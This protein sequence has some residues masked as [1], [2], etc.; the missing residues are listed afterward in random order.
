MRGIEAY[1][2]AKRHRSMRDQEA[3]VFLRVNA[4]L[5]A[6]TGAAADPVALAR[7]MADNERLWNAVMDLMRDPANALPAPVR[8]S[9]LSLAHAVRR[10]QARPAPDVGFLVGVNEQIAA[11]LSGI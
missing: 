1:G 10:E 3:D 9:V 4:M 6:G 11:G 7:A 8:A 2:Q 5:R